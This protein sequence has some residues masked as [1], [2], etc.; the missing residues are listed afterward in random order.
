MA[1]LAAAQTG[2]HN[3]T[4]AEG[5]KN[6]KSDLPSANDGTAIGDQLRILL[7]AQNESSRPKNE[8]GTNDNAA[9]ECGFADA[10]EA[11]AEAF[12]FGDAAAGFEQVTKAEKI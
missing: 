4:D 2:P 3:V 10:D 8:P 11:G 5:G 7:H 9:K 12:G 1:Q 6:D